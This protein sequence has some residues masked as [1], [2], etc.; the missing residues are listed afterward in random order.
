[1]K[2]DA[3]KPALTIGGVSLRHGLMLAPLAG[4]SDHPFRRICRSLGAEFTVSEMVSAKSLCYEKKS[5]RVSVGENSKSAPLAKVWA[6][7]VPMAVQL[8][9]SEP[10][11]MAEAA[12]MVADGSYAGCTSEARPAAIDINMGCPVHKIVSNGEGSALLRDISLAG[13][14]VRAVCRAVDLPVTVKIRIGFDAEHICAVEMAKELEAAGAAAI[15]VHGR[16]REQMYRPGVN[17]EAI[18]AVKAAVSIPVIGNGDILSAADALNMKK[19]T[20]CDGLM[21]ARGAMG[22]PWLFAEIAAA[23]EGREFAP[24]TLEE[25]IET[26]IGQMRRMLLEKG[27]RVGFAESKKQM[28]WYIHGVTGAAE[29]R[30]R[31][32]TATN[33]DEAEDILRRL[34]R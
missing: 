2:D 27:E 18:A 24:P 12:A 13:R 22:N 1:M 10:E 30:G 34:V 21:I 28:A 31:L 20:G 6:D 11:F 19:V 16:T 8:F 3:M 17:L 23:L 9:G 7:D 14:I 32:M 26:A 25:R 4:V 33:P 29:A 15:C 5:R